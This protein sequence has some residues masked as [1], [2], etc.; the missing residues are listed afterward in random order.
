MNPNSGQ[1]IALLEGELIPGGF[2]PVAPHVAEAQLAGQ[3]VLASK[4]LKRLRKIHRKARKQGR[5]SQR[6]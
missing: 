1:V 2:V 5:T 4:S 3:K 6:N